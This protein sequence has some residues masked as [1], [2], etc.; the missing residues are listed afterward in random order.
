[1][2][3]SPLPHP[4]VSP[5]LHT[6]TEH[7]PNGT[8]GPSQHSQSSKR[9]RANAWHRKAGR[10]VQ[11]W[12][13]LIVVVGL[14]HWAI[15]Q[16]R[17]LLIHL[18]TLGA[19]TNSIQLWSQHFTENF[20]HTRLPE[21]SRAWQVRRIWILNAGIAI[22]LVGKLAN[23][24][25]V[26]ATGATV[27]GGSLL[28]HACYL[29]WQFRASSRGQRYRH[30]VSTYI[31]AAAC[32][33]IGAV[34][35]AM[36]AAEAWDK[37]KLL[38][39]HLV[40]N[41]LG[42]VGLTAFASLMV[43]FPTLW[44]TQAGPEHIRSALGLMTL[45]V[46]VATG[47]AL[48]DVPKAAAAGLILYAAGWLV[49][50]RSWLHCVRTVL[51]DPRDRISYSAVGVGLAPLWLLYGLGACAVSALQAQR[52]VDIALPTLPLLVG[53]A[54][55]LLISVLSFLL[56]SNIGGGPAA[57]RTG[58][59]VM[60]RAGL[61]RATLLNVGLALWLLA[62]QSWLR[63]ALSLLVFA[64][65]AVFLLLVPQAVRAQLGVIRKKREPIALPDSPRY[66]QVSLGVATLALVVACFGGLA[67]PVAPLPA[68]GSSG[69]PV[70]EVTVE[71][72]G[73]HFAPDVI[74]VPAG[75]EL[76][77]TL[78]NN[79]DQPHDLRLDNG[80]QSGRLLPG[81]TITF[82]A[83]AINAAIEGWC[84]IAGHRQQGMTLQ[85]VPE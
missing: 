15:P 66:N 35:G 64:S 61:L 77:I 68:S 60:G 45:G 3:T 37:E 59:A 79:D 72:T 40:V 63:V 23:L 84:T 70:T 8:D 2:S 56:P 7:G 11:I 19:V 75:N 58:L 6:P 51:H 69:G 36:M 55:Q 14:F 43:L 47:A 42:F 33:P 44:R 18:F 32:L 29:G 38:L 85:V 74:T 48:A 41:L 20:L 4:T 83:G 16:Y 28:F 5:A 26:T 53:F 39:A 22:T 81:E 76:S 54:A 31:I 10:P 49:A 65:L 46:T 57:T 21:E 71:M 24:W 67:A 12:L 50:G 27:V 34:F 80:A 9:L 62:D 13:A 73:M 78:V 25:P 30:L 17:W 82:S 1:M 52:V